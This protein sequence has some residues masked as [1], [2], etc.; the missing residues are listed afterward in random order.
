MP[1][2][3]PGFYIKIMVGRPLLLLAALVSVAMGV[4][5]HFRSKK[6]YLKSDNFSNFEWAYVRDI[7]LDFPAYWA[8]SPSIS[9]KS[10]LA[11]W[12]PWEAVRF[13]KH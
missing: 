11:M 5:K 8:F 2:Q 10:G 1:K 4:G 9:F 3:G 6:K 13:S 7:V 12:Q